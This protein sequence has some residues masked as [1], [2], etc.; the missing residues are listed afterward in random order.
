VEAGASEAREPLG[1]VRFPNAPSGAGPL[2]RNPLQT[3]QLSLVLAALLSA[4]AAT[5]PGARVTKDGAPAPLDVRRGPGEARLRPSA[6]PFGAHDS[7][8]RRT[9]ARGRGNGRAAPAFLIEMRRRR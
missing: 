4:F 7:S 3:D 9:R 1:A 8:K 6:V 2:A 5:P